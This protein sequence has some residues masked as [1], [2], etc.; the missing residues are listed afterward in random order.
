MITAE[1]IQERINKHFEKLINTRPSHSNRASRLGHPCERYLVYCRLNWEEEEPMTTKTIQKL[2]EGN[3]QERAVVELFQQIGFSVNNQQKSYHWKK[4]NITGHGD[5]ILYEYITQEELMAEI[6]ST[7]PHTFDTINSVDD[8]NK[9]WWTKVWTDQMQTYMILEGKDRSCMVLKNRDNGQIKIFMLELD[10]DKAEQLLQKAER[11]NEYVASETYPERLNRTDVCEMCS[12]KLLCKPVMEWESLIPIDCKELSDLLETY[13]K[14]SCEGKKFKQAESK[15]KDMFK[16][17]KETKALIE[18]EG[19]H[20]WLRKE[21]D[22]RVTIKIE[23]VG[24]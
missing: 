21:G 4:Y 22:K 11:V 6:K 7:N 23:K 13:W 19:F 24:G 1:E 5:G 12:F 2:N 8:F 17:R 15:I 16:K 18:G 14:Y 10:Y 20:T 3:I 9:K